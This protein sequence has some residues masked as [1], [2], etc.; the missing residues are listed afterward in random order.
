MYRDKT[1]LAV[2]P[3]RGGSKRLPNK[4][5]KPLLGK[6][7]IVW[8]IEQANKSKYLDKIIVSTDSQKI[9]KVARRYNA[10]VPFQR[11]KKISKD[12]VPL[13][14]VVIHALEFYKRKGINF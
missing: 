10:E 8:T 2:I 3:A 6:P 1:I 14:D 9:T 13:L 4:N 11:P 7:L 5:I 12:N